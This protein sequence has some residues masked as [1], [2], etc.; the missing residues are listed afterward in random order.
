[1]FELIQSEDKKL[2]RDGISHKWLNMYG[3]NHG[4]KEEI[5]VRIGR[6]I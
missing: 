2:N 3:L 5:M 4:T 6:T 1:M